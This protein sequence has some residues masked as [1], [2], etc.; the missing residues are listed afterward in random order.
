MYMLICEIRTTHYSGQPSRMCGL[1]SSTVDVVLLCTC[2]YMYVYVT[3]CFDHQCLHSYPYPYT[4]VTVSF[5]PTSYIVTEGEGEVANLSLVRCGDIGVTFVVT[6]TTTA[7]TAK[8]MQL[9][10]ILLSTELGNPTRTVSVLQPAYPVCR[11]IWWY[12]IHFI[13]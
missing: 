3:R 13:T 11:S 1:A 6:V 5:D 2:T 10:Y 9:I 4:P 12:L 8:G 7:G